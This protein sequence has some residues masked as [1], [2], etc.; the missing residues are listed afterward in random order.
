MP[1]NNPLKALRGEA[2]LEYLD[3]SILSAS[4][5]DPKLVANL[6]MVSRPRGPSVDDLVVAIGFPKI[7]VFRGD[8]KSATKVIEEGMHAAYGR[9]TRLFPNGRGET[10]PTP[11]FEVEANWPSGMSG[12]PVINTRGEVIGIVSRSLEPGIE[13]E[14][15]VAWATWLQAI[16][17]FQ[18]WLPSLSAIN[19]HYR[20]GWGI[21]RAYPWHLA[22][23]EPTEGEAR[24][25]LHTLP[26]GYSVEF[27]SWRLGSDDFSTV[28]ENSAT[29]QD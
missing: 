4:C 26:A 3:L 29:T 11:V 7:N 5:P 18:Q 8:Q 16:P 10:L 17:Q 15:G 20:R 24:R 13:G 22:S 23:V 6:P 1:G 28:I 9:V 2:D 27:G 14:R 12:G 25:I 21:L 19:T